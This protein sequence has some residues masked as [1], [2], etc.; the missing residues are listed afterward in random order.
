MNV[1]YHCHVQ[2]QSL[3]RQD[4]SGNSSALETWQTKPPAP[5][6]QFVANCS[7][8]HC[9]SYLENQ[10]DVRVISWGCHAYL[11]VSAKSLQF[12]KTLCYPMDFSWLLGFSVHETLQARILDGVGCRALLQGNL[13]DPGIE[14]ISSALQADSLPTEPLRKSP[15]LSAAL[16]FVFCLEFSTSLL[17]YL[18]PIDL[19]MAQVNEIFPDQTCVTLAVPRTSTAPCLFLSY[20]L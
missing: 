18:L 15:L 13:P 4:K 20:F 8:S 10:R 19:A 12:Y 9:L 11:C 3:Y 14:L 5:N 1:T 17:P 16:L 6:L 2:Q 7:E